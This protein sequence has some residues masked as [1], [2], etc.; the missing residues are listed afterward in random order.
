M[1]TYEQHSAMCMQVP[2]CRVLQLS[3]CHHLCV[4]SL[5]LEQMTVPPGVPF[6]WHGVVLSGTMW[7]R[8]TPLAQCQWRFERTRLDS[9]QRHSVSKTDAT[10]GTY[11]TALEAVSCS[12]SRDIHTGEQ[13]TNEVPLKRD[14]AT[15]RAKLDADTAKLLELWARLAPTMR[16]A[17]LAMAEAAALPPLSTAPAGV[18]S[19]VT[20]VERNRVKGKPKPV[21]KGKRTK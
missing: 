21:R 3:A 5:P 11:R 19:T 10:S 8:E 14:R 17:L 1:L 4:Q 6:Q 9:N 13:G 2:L 12:D 18:V 16:G 20:A 7:E 15:R